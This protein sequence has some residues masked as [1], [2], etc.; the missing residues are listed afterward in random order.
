MLSFA[1]TCMHVITG[2]P[3]FSRTAIVYRGT[4]LQVLQQDMRSG[5]EGM[6]ATIAASILLADQAALEGDWRASILHHRGLANLCKHNASMSKYSKFASTRTFTLSQQLIRT[7][8]MSTE[9]IRSTADGHGCLTS[10]ERLRRYLSQKMS[11]PAFS[12]PEFLGTFPN[13]PASA[14]EQISY[15]GGG[16]GHLLL[17]ACDVHELRAKVENPHDVS[18]RLS[19][20]SSIIQCQE[21]CDSWLTEMPQS[22]VTDV[23]DEDFAALVLLAYKTSIDL[24]LHRCTLLLRGPITLLPSPASTMAI[25]FIRQA[26][27]VV[28]EC[29][30]DRYTLEE[31]SIFRDCMK[32]PIW[33]LSWAQE[34]VAKDRI[35]ELASECGMLPFQHGVVGPAMAYSSDTG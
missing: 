22:I 24:V 4:A 9:S 11:K 14:S 17:I 7:R 27:N 26:R 29:P 35:R 10:L 30:T 21:E 12:N 28:F 8:K 25:A 19:H 23:L 32:W 2:S 6:D 31:V 5:I 15:A 34:F 1:A 20:L 13:P 3:D 16:L 18:A 33:V